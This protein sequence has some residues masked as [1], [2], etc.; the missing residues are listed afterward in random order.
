MVCHGCGLKCHYDE[1]NAGGYALFVRGKIFT[2]YQGGDYQ[3]ENLLPE[4]FGC[5]RGRKDKPMRPEHMD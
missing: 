3:L 5:N 1:N 2:L 4:C